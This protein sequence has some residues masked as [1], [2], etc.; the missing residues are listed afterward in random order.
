MV[1]VTA[2]LDG[3]MRRTVPVDG[4]ATQTAPKPTA[5]E[6]AP[7][8]DRDGGDDLDGRRVDRDQAAGG[9]NHPHISLAQPGQA[10]ATTADRRWQLTGNR[11][12]DQVEANEPTATAVGGPQ[13]T[14]AGRHSV[15]RCEARRDGRQGVR[16][17]VDPV[18]LPDQ[19][20]GPYR[21]VRDG[22]PIG[23][24]TDRELDEA[25]AVSE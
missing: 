10:L 9:A 7:D 4:S 8:R 18:D 6:T 23:K 19:V 12:G 21:V 16:D 2:R 22:L 15:A 1:A 14:E 11:S 5:T 17:G 13:A 25:R 3:S 20:A 24:A